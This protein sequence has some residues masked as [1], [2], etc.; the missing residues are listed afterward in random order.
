MKS[1]SQ[2]VCISLFLF[3]LVVP[4][5]YIILREK[6]EKAL[7]KRIAKGDTQSQ[8]PGPIDLSRL[9]IDD[10]LRAQY[11][12]NIKEVCVIRIIRSGSRGHGN[13]PSKFQAFALETNGAT[14]T[15]LEDTEHH[16]VAQQAKH[17]AAVLEVPFYDKSYGG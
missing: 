16:V 13:F 10:E 17:L 4:F 11:Q 9:V 3:S 14:H 12:E 2:L 7:F 6:R 1:I 15:F 5:V 8:L